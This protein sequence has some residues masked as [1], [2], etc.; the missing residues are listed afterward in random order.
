MWVICWLIRGSAPQPQWTG[1]NHWQTNGFAFLPFRAVIPH[2][3]DPSV[4]AGKT[5]GAVITLAMKFVVTKPWRNQAKHEGLP[6][7]EG[8]TLKIL[9]FF[10]SEQVSLFHRTLSTCQWCLVKM[11]NTCSCT[12]YIF[13][14]VS[15][16]IH[17]SMKGNDYAMFTFIFYFYIF[18]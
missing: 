8:Q 2:S 10:S 16:L 9:C 17:L 12:L 6:N 13:I 18:Y 7:D 11:L 3:W 1:L 14:L 4:R 15:Y 5:S